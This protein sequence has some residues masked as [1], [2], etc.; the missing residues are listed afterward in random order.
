M[1]QGYFTQSGLSNGDLPL[2]VFPPVS[3]PETR[4]LFERAWTQF[5]GTLTSDKLAVRV[6]VDFK[7]SIRRGPTVLAVA[8]LRATVHC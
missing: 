1:S 5:F 7:V 4:K 2:R 6:F 8:T 3:V